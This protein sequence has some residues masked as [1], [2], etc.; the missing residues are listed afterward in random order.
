MYPLT[1]D[2][3]DFLLSD[4]AQ[5]ELEGLAEIDLGGRA[6]LKVLTR[7]RETYAADEAAVLLDQARLRR[8]A[9][10]K[11]P[12]PHRLLFVDEGLQQATSRAVAVYR[13]E[14]FASYQNLAD[15]GCGIGADTIAFAEAG[16]EVLAVERDPIRARIAE[17]NLEALGLDSLVRVVRADWTQIP[18]DVQAAFA[19]PS[20]RVDGQRILRLDK[21]EPPI[22]AIHKLRKQ[23][24]D[25]V[26][27]VAPGVSDEEVP[28]GAEVEFISESGSMKEAMLRFGGL[29][30]GVAR[31]ATLLPGP[32]YLDSSMPIGDVP[33]HE[34]LG[35]L[36]EPDPAVL[37]ATLVQTLATRL[38][39]AQ[40]DKFIAYLT[41][42]AFV[43]TPFARAWRVL[44][45]GKF[46]LKT[47]NQWLRELEV[48]NVI[49][50]KRG[51]PIETESFQR[52]L[53][54]VSKGITVTVFFTRVCDRPW[55]IVGTEIKAF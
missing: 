4:R 53:K 54:T 34:P 11:F 46:H 2:L 8:A 26:V 9:V 17:I 13:A 28:S 29:Q 27:K 48:G 37:R 6:T 1:E 14:Q 43:P 15:L 30:L 40:L 7:L 25:I 10:G 22:S 33:V 38:G 51:S 19:D 23:V 52:R 42:D 41:S 32:Y 47:L 44:K 12:S 35:F 31:R 50:K 21:M 55:M 49:I 3:V 45:Q 16:L 39:A 20:R 18:I 5:N 24:P 36:Y